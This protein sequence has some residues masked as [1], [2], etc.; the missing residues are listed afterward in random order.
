MITLLLSPVTTGPSIV[1]LLARNELSRAGRCP[2]PR[3]PDRVE[4]DASGSVL[5][6]V[7][8]SFPFAARTRDDG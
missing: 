3:F 4:A 2:L 1:L 5:S 6:S 7:C 8:I